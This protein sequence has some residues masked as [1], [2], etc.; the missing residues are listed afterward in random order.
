M[1]RQLTPLQQHV[2]R[3]L[4]TRGVT[5]ATDW[6]AWYPLTTSQARAALMRL[7]RRSLVDAIGWQ[8]RA[9]TYGLTEAGWAT[10]EALDTSPLE[11]EA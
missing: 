2:L 7:A 6:A 3:V 1:P 8:G 4:S 9:R 10:V 5:P 11:E